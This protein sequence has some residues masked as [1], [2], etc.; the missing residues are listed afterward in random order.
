VSETFTVIENPVLLVS[1]NSSDNLCNGDDTG[2]IDLTINGGLP[3]YSVSWTG[4]AGFSSSVQDIE[5]LLA[6]VYEVTVTDA[7][8]CVVV[9]QETVNQPAALT[10]TI[11]PSSLQCFENN[12]GQITATA[13][14]GTPGYNYSWS[15][16]NGF[17]A[18]GP[19]IIALPSGTYSLTLTDNNGCEYNEDVELVEPD[20]LVLD[21]VESPIS[22]NGDSD[23]EIDLTVSG[24]TPPFTFAWS[25]PAGFT[26]G[27]EDIAG[28]ST[29]LYSVLVTDANNCTVSGNYDLSEPLPISLSASL[30]DPDCASQANGEIDLTISNGTPPYDV[31]W[32]GPDGFTSTDEDLTGLQ[33]GDYTV[34]VTDA[35]NCTDSDTYTVNEPTILAATF[36]VTEVNCFGGNNGS[37]TSS[38]SGGVAPYEFAW[39]GPNGFVST[40]QNISAL[41]A[42]DYTLV[43]TDL[44]GCSQ[45]FD[46]TIDQ[47]EDLTVNAIITDVLCFGEAT[48]AIDIS[49]SGGTAT[50]SF[51]WT[52][53]AG[54]TSSNQN[55]SGLLAGDYSLVVTDGNNCTYNFDYVLGE[56]AEIELI[57]AITEVVC[58]GESTGGI[59]LSV[60]GGTPNFTYDWTGP[61]GFIA[62]TEDISDIEAG[63]YVINLT[64]ANGCT[65]TANF[66]IQEQ[67]EVSLTTSSMNISCFGADDG[68][69]N[70][71]ASGGI[72][73]FTFEWTGPNGFTSAA[74]DITGLEAGIYD[75]IVTDGNGCTES[76]QVEIIEPTEIVLNI[77]ATNIDCFG[78][79]DGSISVLTSGG[80]SPYSFAWT[81]PNGFGSSDADISSLEPGDYDLIVQDANGCFAT[82]L[83]TITES[84]ELTLSV[85]IFDSNCGQADGLAVAV[86]SGGT[87]VL[88]YSWEDQEGIELTQ[89][90]SLIDVF[91]GTYVLTV[92]DDLG[93]SV[94]S[95]AVI[96]DT[97]GT[98]SGTV[99]NPICSGGN[100]GAIDAEIVGGTSPYIFDWSDGNGFSA[101]Q[102][103]I[104][105]IAA[106]TYFLTVTDANNCVFT[107]TF[108]VVDPAPINV[109]VEFQDVTCAGGDGS[110]TITVEDSNSPETI[111]WTGP[112]GFVAVGTSL[113]NLAPGD[114]NYAIA[115]ALGC[116]ANG[117]ISLSAVPT[118]SL[119]DSITNIACAGNAEGEIFIEASGGVPPL[120]FSWTGPSGFSSS[121]EDI[122]NLIPGDY[123]LE[124]TDQST[125][126]ASQTY[127]ITEP[128]SI[129]VDIVVTEP[130]CNQSDGTLEAIITGGTVATDYLIAWEDDSGTLVSNTSLVENLAP[131]VYSLTVVDDNGCA[132]QEDVSLSNPG[133]DITSTI[134]PESCNGNSDGAIILEIADVAEPYTVNWSGPDGFTSID[135]DIF[136]LSQGT[137]VYTLV[138]ADGCDFTESL[139][140]SAPDTILVTALTMNTCFG[141]NNGQIE[142]DPT[143]GEA[144]FTINWSGPNA[145]TSSELIISALEPGEYTLQIID[146]AG[147]EFN[148]IYTISESPEIVT[149]VNLQNVVCFGESNGAIDLTLSGGVDPLTIEWTGP[150][151]F[152]SNLEDLSDLSNGEYALT[153]TDGNGCAVQE[154]ITITQPEE[155]VVV[156]D[157]TASG[158]SD[159]PNSG[160]ISLFPE[161][162]QGGYT[163]TWTGPDGFSSGQFDILNLTPGLYSYS[164]SDQAGCTLTDSIEINSV[165]PLELIFTPTE[166]LCF[167]GET[168]SIETEI[169][170]G[171]APYEITWTGPDG[172]SASV[173]TLMNL[174][175]G[176]YSLTVVDSVSCELG[177]TILL[178]QPEPLNLSLNSIDATCVNVADGSIDAVTTGGTSD[179]TYQWSGPDDFDSDLSEIT[180]LLPGE[181]F[182]NVTDVNGCELADSTLINSLFDLDVEAG[183]DTSLCPSDLPV[184]LNGSQAGGD[185]FYW[186]FEGDTLS[187]VAG[188]TIDRSF[189][190]TFELVLIGSNGA[191]SETDTTL[192][193]ILESP[194]VDAGEDLRVFVE[195]I[196]TL[197]GN[198]T[199]G[200][201]IGYL[202]MPNPLS[203]FDST[204]ANPSGFLLGSEEFMVTVTDANGCES[205]D[206]VFVEVLPDIE[207]TSGFTPNGD[208]VNDQWIIDNIELFPSMVVHVYNRW[209]AEVFE[210]QG[211]NADVA[212]DGTYEGSIL[213]S[214]TYYYTIELNDRRFP[215]PITGPLTL[216]R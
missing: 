202:W 63:T 191:C 3:P 91:A 138:G 33:V 21:F 81:G 43:L 178:T 164:V 28:L 54:F 11:T 128:D 95:T 101:N 201:A 72:P 118:I 116:E 78:N 156:E 105:G 195:E 206:T 135:E 151:G 204:A 149:E 106:G 100:D 170:G 192:I 47:P 27:N 73:P 34:V 74:Q 109:V 194:D 55:I 1:A 124:V 136:N 98:L 210:S 4:P 207:V 97:N 197:G 169:S 38:A 129:L 12:S 16:P 211:Y 69:I 88:T 110:I 162:G 93:C 79:M 126:V 83:V 114:Y 184:L 45:T 52:G 2:S 14:G 132:Y 193:E 31:S 58:A 65:A 150:D 5:D 22:C 181:Y 35:G 25:G 29:G 61:N 146:N 187:S 23:G 20:E 167:G 153:V 87:G 90:D 209:G 179:Y 161:G 60:N 198:P 171:L 51:A 70:L 117:T 176:E 44:N 205:V 89:N 24:G 141:E 32:S 111:D 57:G 19:T 212:W 168:G 76:A 189:E 175:A 15:G 158:C 26:S 40:N 75:V 174:V 196:F 145:F 80:S 165:E 64:D 39:T 152:V 123:S 84:P 213:P 119:I 6:G 49:L 143:G 163:V 125:C 127:T 166:P 41:E 182:L 203:A 107:E 188:I 92:T 7:A 185:Q 122:T 130:N 199:S 115:D 86:A 159:E 30:T 137:Y 215:D 121:D 113:V 144:P 177:E 157:I 53:P 56:A 36:D 42:G 134:T 155:L 108:E 140:V 186:T 147:C 37:I 85:D 62:N 104:I 9:V 102:E 66:L 173:D 82:D 172:F 216:H 180:A 112:D 133:G 103:D 154:T 120:Q 8:N 48:G 190:G 99:T 46:L 71:G 96:S 50:Y 77:T 13:Q 200:D 67:F 10:A 94:Q 142:I 131:G 17:F 160:S 139:E 208:G 214:G 148:E 183:A 59:D 68:E 18:S